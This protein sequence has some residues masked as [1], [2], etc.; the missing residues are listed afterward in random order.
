MNETDIPL[1]TAE[2][3]EYRAYAVFLWIGALILIQE[4]LIQAIQWGGRAIRR[5]G[6][7]SHVSALVDRDPL[8][9]ATY[10]G[11]QAV[12]IRLGFGLLALAAKLGGL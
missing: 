12:S 3:I 5:L 8:A 7:G 11:Q 1:T 10:Y 9:A 2:F 4:V 6:F